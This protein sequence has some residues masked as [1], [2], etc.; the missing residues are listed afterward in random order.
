[1][2]LLIFAV[3][4]LLVALNA[5][6]VGAEFAAVSV[7]KSAIKQLAGEGNPFA[8]RVLP[9][10]EDGVK[11]D[12]YVATCQIGITVS[13]LI[14]G[15]FSEYT[16][17]TRIS[18]LFENVFGLE[19][20]TSISAAVVVILV[21]L[22]I[23]Q[24]VLAELVP[25]SVALLFPTRTLL[26]TYVP[27]A[28]STFMFQGLIVL[29][30][31]CAT[32]ILK[33]FGFQTSTHRHIHTSDELA[34]LLAQV[35]EDGVLEPDE[36]ARLQRAL[37][38]DAWSAAELMVARRSVEAID[39][40]APIPEI[41]N[42]VAKSPYTRLPVYEGRSDNVIMIL[43]TKDV[44]AEIA[45]Y[46]ELK[47]IEPM[48]RPLIAV[49]EVMKADKLLNLMRRKRVQM[50]SIIDEYGT[51]VGIVTVEDILSEVFGAIGD[52]F[53]AGQPIAEQLPD[54]RVRLPGMMRPDEA[55]H[56]IGVLW[57]GES[58]TIAGLVTEALRVLPSPG[59]KVVIQDVEVEVEEV[60][61]RV[62]R[63]V[64]V[65]PLRSQEKSEGST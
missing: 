56:W 22:A 3:I 40:H 42:T 47:S 50:V 34:I 7:R 61:E 39:R 23:L 35:H 18:P 12:R 45:A 20:Q 51:F 65:K 58:N 48:L 63:T 2:L 26:L 21:V 28:W 44:V 46:G 15:A 57:K 4:V 53:K 37:S 1:M 38:L 64:I 32:L 36:H 31:G 30:N 9:I 55:Q 33:A 16:L 43:H 6:Y 41:I 52:E 10:L 11:L 62:V 5:L 29:F 14:L 17:A 60:E 25:K 8:K 24:M 19:H 59:D 27:I 13:S 54:G 49:P